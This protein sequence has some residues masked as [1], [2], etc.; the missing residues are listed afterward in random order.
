MTNRARSS[1]TGVCLIIGG[2]RRWTSAPIGSSGCRLTKRG[3]VDRI[4]E[5]RVGTIQLCML[6]EITAVKDLAD[7]RVPTRSSGRIWTTQRSSMTTKERVSE[8]A[9]SERLPFVVEVFAGQIR[10]ADDE[11]R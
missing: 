5:G 9:T 6:V 1:L 11:Y 8:P 10:E 7:D 2:K 3:V 4:E